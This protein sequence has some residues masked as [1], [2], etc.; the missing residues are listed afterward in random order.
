[1]ELARPPRG[2][3]VVAYQRCGLE[4][5]SRNRVCAGWP[6]RL[7]API[8]LADVVQECEKTETIER[9]LVQCGRGCMLK[10]DRP[11]GAKWQQL[12]SFPQLLFLGSA[13]CVPQLASETPIRKAVAEN[14]AGADWAPRP[15]SV[16]PRGLAP[17]LLIERPAREVP[18]LKPASTVGH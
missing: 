14:R 4:Y 13:R 17:T 9:A 7:E 6:L 15:A 10:V 3:T 18:A 12:T 16:Q 11:V 5:V 8:A 2:K 1:V